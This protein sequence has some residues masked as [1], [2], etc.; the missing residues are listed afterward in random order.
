MAN[1]KI[2]ELNDI[3]SLASNDV[4]VAVDI[5]ADETHKIT[6]TN[7][8]RTLPDG[9]AAAPALAF[10]DD[11]NTGI[12]TPAE[13]QLSFS[14]GG[15]QRLRID[16]SGTVIISG[17]L[18]V[19]GATTTVQST[20]V[21]IDDKNIELGSVASPTNTTADGGGITLKGATDKT[22]KWINSTGYWTFNTG[23]DVAGECQ[24]TSLDVNGVADISG[25]LIIGS[26]L[27]LL[28]TEGNKNIDCNLG[29]S[30]LS[31]R[32]TSGGDA[33]HETMARFVRNGASEL[34]HNN[35]KK[36]QTKSD[37]IDV[38]GEVQC[39]SL[40]VDGVADITG[41]VT[42]HG[43]LDLQDSDKIL[44]GT[45]DDLEIYHDGSNS[46]IKDAGTGELKIAGTTRM[47]NTANSETIA[48]F[49]PDG[50]VELFH[51][52]SK[53]LETKSDGINVIG[54]V[55]CDSLDVDGSADITGTVTLHGNLDLQDD[56]KIL[57]GTGDDL[58]IFH[59]GSH[60]VIADVGTGNLQIRA[61]DFRVTNSANTETLIVANS[62]EA[63]K[64]YY[65]NSRKIETKSDGVDVTAK[66][67]DSL[68][69]DGVADITGNV[70]LHGNLDLQDNDILRI[71]TGD[72]LQIKHDG[73]NTVIDNNTGDLYIQT[74]GSGDDIVLQAADDII[75]QPQGSENGIQ[76]IGNG[77]VR[78]AHNNDFK[79]PSHSALMLPVKFS[80]THYLFRLL[81]G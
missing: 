24:C 52:N 43:N 9:T 77:S 13:N 38:T 67:S 42:L 3:G 50:Q 66:S 54:E 17:N 34:Y 14:T 44:L 45:G 16:S 55:Q 41:T 37:G 5:S 73:T 63:V 1:I 39:D 46:F 76:I 30:A 71:G 7:L 25:N 22:I 61:G 65:D 31:I 6:T 12:F 15:T 28:G 74:T 78:F 32:G 8:F 11:S 62:N 56:D 57:I 69:V 21:T 79:R 70:T 4:L 81:L 72:D 59:N 18:Q 19:D 53:K 2:T 80:V 48:L 33:N 36:F 20:T 51:N 29:S 40:D 26:E 27:G 68:D 60:S 49:V 35:S 64:L 75:L 10:S 23:I 58:E 47:V